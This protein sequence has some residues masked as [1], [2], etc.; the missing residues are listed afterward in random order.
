MHI[1]WYMYITILLLHFLTSIHFNMGPRAKKEE[2][3]LDQI[4]AKIDS[5]GER[6][7]NMETKIIN[8]EKNT[9]RIQSIEQDIAE[10]K[11]KFDEQKSQIEENT[12]SIEFVSREVEQLQKDNESNKGGLKDCKNVIDSLVRKTT[13]LE[14]DKFAV[15][16]QLRKSE[17]H[18]KKDCL[19]FD[20]FKE[21][22]GAKENCEEKILKLIKERLKITRSIKL[23]RCHRLG[24]FQKT[25]NRLILAKFVEYDDRQDVLRN[26]K[27]LK[28]DKTYWIRGFYSDTTANR[29]KALVPIMRYMQTVKKLKCTLINDILIA[30]GKRYTLESAKKLPFCQDA[31]TRSN[32]NVIAFSGQMSILSN[33]YVCPFEVNK[34][35]YNCVEQYFQS[36]KA[37]Q[38]GS[39]DVAHKISNNTDPVQ[40]KHL[41]ASLQID[42]ECWQSAQTMKT[43]VHSKFR[44]NQN[45]M[46]YLKNTGQLTLVHANAYDKKWASGLGIGDKD[47]L[48]PTKYSG[49]NL[50]GETLME[51]RGS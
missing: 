9:D 8:I 19:L 37:I 36:Q 41:G 31:A 6:M 29:R 13:M 45:L 26:A 14:V 48:N 4:L 27:N 3:K 23:Q 44:Q 5:M 20:G 34:V 1:Y 35:T 28:P 16:E 7:S 11:T 24:R 30:D 33:F 50:L 22:E 25:K 40:Q 10:M 47:T 18:S 39:S 2:E 38:N 43:A 12:E 32:E 21:E 46:D 17:D 42:D 51:L 15:Q 49:Q